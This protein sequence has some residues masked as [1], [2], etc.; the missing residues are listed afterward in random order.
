MWFKVHICYLF[1]VVSYQENGICYS[2]IKVNYYRGDM[3]IV[4]KN[5]NLQNNCQSQISTYVVRI[6]Y[7]KHKVITKEYGCS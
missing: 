7:T 4:L 6:P 3:D 1:Y 5:F 2:Y